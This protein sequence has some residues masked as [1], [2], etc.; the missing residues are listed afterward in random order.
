MSAPNNQPVSEFELAIPFGTD[1]NSLL[2]IT[3]KLEDTS[4]LNLIFSGSASYSTNPVPT[5]NYDGTDLILRAIDLNESCRKQGCCNNQISVW[6]IRLASDLE[7]NL[8]IY[9][10]MRFLITGL[11]RTWVWR[12]SLFSNNGALVDFRVGDVRGTEGFATNIN[13]SRIVPI[14]RLFVFIIAPAWLELRTASP[15]LHYIRLL[16]GRPWWPYLGFAS[17]VFKEEKLVI[18][19]WRDDD[20]VDAN[21]KTFH[22]FLDLSRHSPYSTVYAFLRAGIVLLGF[23]GIAWFFYDRGNTTVDY[24]AE[25]WKQFGGLSVVVLF[26]WGMFKDADHLRRLKSKS[27]SLFY[28]FTRFALRVSKAIRG[29]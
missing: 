6:K 21:Q 11:G 4:T 24:V 2:D 5:I 7:P 12:R 18:Y 3:D 20:G 9:V 22:S 14:E 25:R 28:T 10:R 16:E 15:E 29:K 13:E 8:P 23:L 26:L 19:Q 27:I 1:E 17:S